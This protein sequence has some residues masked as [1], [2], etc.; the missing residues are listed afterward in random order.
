MRILHWDKKHPFPKK[1]ILRDWRKWAAQNG[2]VLYSTV[3]LT[4]DKLS[5]LFEIYKHPDPR[6][7]DTYLLYHPPIGT[8]TNTEVLCILPDLTVLNQILEA[9][10]QMALSVMKLLQQKDDPE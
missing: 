4:S 8:T 5:I 2:Y 3:P 7:T 10:K 1:I 6:H 9:E